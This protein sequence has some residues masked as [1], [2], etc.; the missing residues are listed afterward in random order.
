LV[1]I[2]EFKD[3]DDLKS[4]LSL[5]DTYDFKIKIFDIE[6]EKMTLVLEK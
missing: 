1:H 2:S 5:G 6:S 3:I 4:N